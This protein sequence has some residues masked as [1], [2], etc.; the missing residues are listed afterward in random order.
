MGPQNYPSQI[1]RSGEPVVFPQRRVFFSGEGGGKW[2]GTRTFYKL[3]K[4][5]AGF[6]REQ[7]GENVFFACPLTSLIQTDAFRDFMDA[8]RLWDQVYAIGGEREMLDLFLKASFTREQK[9]QLWE[10]LKGYDGPDGSHSPIVVRSSGLNEDS[11]HKSYAGAF[12]SI[13][14][15]NQHP[16]D[17]VRLAQ[18]EAAVK[19]VYASL[20]LQL[21]QEKSYGV[22]GMGGD[23]RMGVMVQ[24]VAGRAWPSPSGRLL[25]YPEAS[26]A[27]F[28]Y[29]YFTKADGFFRLAFGL[30]PGVV[31]N[32]KGSAVV[33]EMGADRPF[34][35][36][37]PRDIVEFSPL[38]FY[39]LDLSDAGRAPQG[40]NDFVRKHKIF[41]DAPEGLF[42]PNC[43]IYDRELNVKRPLILTPDYS[44]AMQLS[45]FLGRSKGSLGQALEVM[46]D[47]LRE[48]FSTEMERIEVDFEGAADRVDGK[49]VVYPLQARP[50]VLGA[51]TRLPQLPQVEADD[52]LLSG[53]GAA[54]WGGQYSIRAVVWVPNPAGGL[55]GVSYDISQELQAINQTLYGEGLRS[56]VLYIVPGRYGTSDGAEGIPGPLL[57]TAAAIAEQRRYAG[58]MMSGGT[59]FFLEMMEANLAYLS[60]DDIAQFN[61]LRLEQ[62][63]S[64]VESGT[65]S[66]IYRLHAPLHLSVDVEN[67]FLLHPNGVA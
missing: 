8:N 37:T 18:L 46:R 35:M 28:S 21:L 27:A 40:E 3:L 11:A 14:L 1:V 49:L 61:S 15:P 44:P 58:E 32:L 6:L 26:F 38:H 24:N 59:H 5:Q 36:F 9:A 55:Y 31:E 13:F 41:T 30:G 12:Y 66:Q 60:I 42:L 23:E 64:R 34:G 62:I 2:Q 22:A 50:M 67:R 57:H 53:T 7:C 54:G 10:L 19:L 16:D 51:N 25:Y 48:A 52:T 17:G 45:K 39:A 43:V 20:Y 29:N 33:V 47:L 63:S 56:Q 4:D 65:Y